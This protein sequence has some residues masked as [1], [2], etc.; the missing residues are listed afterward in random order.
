MV[1]S[2]VFFVI[3]FWTSTINW[4]SIVVSLTF[5]ANRYSA[6]SAHIMNLYK[7]VW[8]ATVSNI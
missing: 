4:P 2:F 1:K 7:Q 3:I 8:R 6:F 5:T